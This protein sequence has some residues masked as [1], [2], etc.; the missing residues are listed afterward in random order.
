MK[1]YVMLRVIALVVAVL[2]VF[3]FSS[4]EAHAAEITAEGTCGTNLTWTLNDEGTLT[5]S[6]TGVMSNYPPGMYSPWM[7][8]AEDVTTIVIKDGV[9]TIGLGAFSGF[10]NLSKLTIPV[11][12]CSI[13]A[14]AFANCSN[15]T[16]VIY[17]G[18]DIQWS[19]VVIG[20][21]NTYL[22]DA[23][24]TN[25]NW[26]DATITEP[27]TCILCGA[28]H[29]NP[30]RSGICGENLTWTLNDEGVLRISG[31]GPMSEFTF[32]NNGNSTRPWQT[33][34]TYIIKRIV[35]EDGVTSISKEAFYDCTSLTSVTIGNSVTRI[36]N[37]AFSDCKHLTD[38]IISDSVTYIG[39]FAFADCT[40]LT[41]VIFG[42][43]VKS[44]GCGAFSRCSNLTNVSIPDSITSIG[45]APFFD[46]SKLEYNLYGNGEYL[47]NS[48]NPYLC[49]MWVQSN[50]DNLVIPSNVKVIN[51]TAFEYAQLSNVY[52]SDLA[53]WCDIFFGTYVDYDG[54]EIVGNPLRYAENLYVNGKLVTEL[55]IPNGVRKISDYAFI[56]FDNLT[57]LS[58]PESVT[59][60]GLSAFCD[61]NSLTRVTYCGTSEQ[62]N[63]ISIESRNTALE[64]VLCNTHQSTSATT[65]KE[66][67]YTT[68][69]EKVSI[70]AAC[71]EQVTETIPAKFYGTSINLGNTL[72]MYFGFYTGLVDEGGKVKF[73]REFADGT[74]KITEKPITSFKKNNSVYDITYTG[75]AA[76]EMCDTIHIYVYNSAG[77]LV[78]EHSDSIRTYIL[79]QLREKDY[80]QEFRTLCV[81]LLNY[82]AEAQT[83]FG[84][85]TGDLAN[86][87]L[88]T[89]ELAEGTQNIASY[90]NKQT[91]T[92]TTAA[93]YGTAYILET[94]I[95]MSMAVRGSYFGDGCYALVSYTDHTGTEKNLR[96]EGKQ[97]NSVYEFVLN[98]MVVAD[99][100]CLLTIEF[101]KADGTLVITVQDSM[102]SYTA[103]NAEY[104]PLAEKML[105][106]S[107]SAYNYLH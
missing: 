20:A 106:F 49:L 37:Y 48:E 8:Y 35:I 13:N 104:Y 40:D 79:R 74:T 16:E 36:D 32:Y 38:I 100:R 4:T 59:S 24:R 25:H 70:C 15:L 51:A 89:K 75:L 22:T 21:G 55:I 7:D 96:L 107:D 23:Q 6:G 105:A 73:V 101:Y 84:Y 18:T 11:S 12:V 99:G 27:K 28:T 50:S 53:A 5:V 68:M 97:N 2:A 86:K 33:Y 83:T 57:S 34:V 63:Q 76:K 69:G 87:E 3:V 60:I 61:C 17:C 90:A 29:G 88:T 44:I 43:N 52:V 19:A 94:K 67:S 103:R 102:E 82:G 95:S 77:T 81:D 56:G 98:E 65:T 80:G 46:C 92:G 62:W 41:S 64:N 26:A 31:T 54:W 9:S 39:D 30:L 10:E 58:I 93:Y 42:N 14:N 1:K 66:S 91:I 45:A 71:G 85:N 47:G 78:G 72:D